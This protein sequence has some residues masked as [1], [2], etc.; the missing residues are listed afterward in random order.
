VFVCTL[1]REL[2]YIRQVKESPQSAM[3]KDGV[4]GHKKKITLCTCGYLYTHMHHPLLEISL[5]EH[6]LLKFPALNTA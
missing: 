5:I 4:L 6:L 2:L 3:Y 1:C